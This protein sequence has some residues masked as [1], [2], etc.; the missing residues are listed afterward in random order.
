L[1]LHL[2]G[3]HPEGPRFLQRGEGSG[4]QYFKLTHYQRFCSADGTCWLG[5]KEKTGCGPVLVVGEKEIL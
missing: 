5:A 3:R 4:V 1:A 2:K